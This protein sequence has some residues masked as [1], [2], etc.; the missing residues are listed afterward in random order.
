VEEAKD[1]KSFQAL[2]EELV[3]LS[4]EAFYWGLKNGFP[5]EYPHD[6]RAK[7]LGE[8][9]YAKRG[10]EGLQEAA[11]VLRQRGVTRDGGG[12]CFLITYNWQ[13]IGEWHA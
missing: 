4:Q 1:A 9:I 8:L 2:V 10:F 6:A 3:S 5:A 7:Q 13:G 12:Q 11:R